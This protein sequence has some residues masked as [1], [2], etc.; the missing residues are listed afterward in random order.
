MP[1]AQEAVPPLE[2]E[3]GALG[4]LQDGLRAD[5]AAAE[6]GTRALRADSDLL[7]DAFLKEERKGEAAAGL[8]RA[9]HAQL[10][11]LDAAVAA[12]HAEADARSRRARRPVAWAAGS[13]GRRR[14]T[15][16][17]KQAMDSPSCLVKRG[18]WLTPSVG[19]HP[20]LAAAGRRLAGPAAGCQWV[21]TQERGP[22]G[23][24]GAAVAQTGAPLRGRHP[25]TPP[26]AMRRCLRE[27][28]AQRDAA[29]RRAAAQA[30]HLRGAREALALRA[31][32]L[33]DAARAA[34]E[35]AGREAE[36]LGLAELVKHQRNRFVHTAQLAGACRAAALPRTHYFTVAPCPVRGAPAGGPAAGCCQQ[37][38]SQCPGRRARLGGAPPSL[39][40][41]S[42]HAA[43]FRIRTWSLPGLLR[44]TP[45]LCGTLD[46]TGM[47]VS[48]GTGVRRE[49]APRAAPV[50]KRPGARC[51]LVL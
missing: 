38:S 3:R 45:L 44:R 16:L 24:R 28:G 9:G 30:G 8:F 36:L 39:Q 13:P 7:I 5:E 11:A 32:E 29:G 31:L 37:P 2:L 50:N 12:Q 19:G 34:R 10:A 1:R 6:G 17:D 48:Y 18:G 40:P 15:A 49:P 21:A 51:A 23:G 14:L 20:A 25:L 35:A 41:T 33:R 43:C 26:G 47:C 46:V 4:R 22:D 42:H 27:L